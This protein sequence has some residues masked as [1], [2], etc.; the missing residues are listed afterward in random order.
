MSTMT[1]AP[2]VINDLSMGNPRESILKVIYNKAEKSAA[3]TTKIGF[4]FVRWAKNGIASLFGSPLTMASILGGLAVSTDRGYHGVA[5][6]FEAGVEAVGKVVAVGERIVRKGL[7]LIADGVSWVLRNINSAWAERFDA[8]RNNTSTL[9]AMTKQHIEDRVGSGVM[10]IRTTRARKSVGMVAIGSS[11]AVFANAATSGAIANSGLFGSLISGLFTPFGIV[12]AI[13]LAFA[14]TFATGFIS[15]NI[16]P[17]HVEL[18]PVIPSEETT[19]TA[20]QAA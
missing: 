1:V 7:N 19:T 14:G 15:N 4:R 3:Q 20:A 6:L 13:G 9:W 2:E 11:A 17:S 8:W 16:D 12:A 18:N 10:A 5:S